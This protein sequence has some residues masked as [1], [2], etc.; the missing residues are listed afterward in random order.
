MVHTYTA[1]SCIANR[2]LVDQRTTTV[3]YKLTSQSWSASNA[4]RERTPHSISMSEWWADG[5]AEVFYSWL[6][7]QQIRAIA[8][9]S[10]GSHEWRNRA[11][12]NGGN[13]CRRHL[14]KKRNREQ[15]F[16]LYVGSRNQSRILELKLRPQSVMWDLDYNINYYGWFGGRGC[17][18]FAFILQNVL[19][20]RRFKFTLF[21]YQ[22][23]RCNQYNW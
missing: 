9:L 7:V 12:G 18:E 22:R 3:S 19:P 4:H 6:G 11:R 2:P 8:C 14:K 15:K 20:I 10:D 16:R 13:A 21:F 17:A 5:V 23:V 1:H